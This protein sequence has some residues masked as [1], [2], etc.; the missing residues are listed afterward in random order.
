MAP[1]SCPLPN[2]KELRKELCLSGVDPFELLADY[3]VRNEQLHCRIAELQRI[4][5]SSTHQSGR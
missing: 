2:K 5:D 1:I 4:I 3:A